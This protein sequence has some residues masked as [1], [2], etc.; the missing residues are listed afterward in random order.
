MRKLVFHT[1]GYCRGLTLQGIDREMLGLPITL[2]PRPS[3]EGEFWIIG[4]KAYPVQES[5]QSEAAQYLRHDCSLPCPDFRPQF[6]NDS[7]VG[8]DSD[9]PNF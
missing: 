7:S 2:D 3:I 6:G 1:C 9:R 5:H 4:G 8:L